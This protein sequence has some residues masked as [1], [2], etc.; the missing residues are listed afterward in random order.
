M[1]LPWQSETSDEDQLNER[2]AQTPAPDHSNR[3][4]PGEGKEVAQASPIKANLSQG[5]D[6]C[7]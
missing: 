6:F 3:A 2:L 7:Q 1:K 5:T 4:H